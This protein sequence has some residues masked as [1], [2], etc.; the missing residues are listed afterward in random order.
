MA[1]LAAAYRLQQA[2]F[3]VQVL[4]AEDH[5]GGRA[6]AHRRD[7]GFTLNT[8]ATVLSSSYENMIGLAT[9][10][11]LEDRFVKV[12]PTVGI[13]A[14]GKVHWLRGAGPGA[15]IDFIRTPLLSAKSKLLL[16]KA[17]KDAFAARKK[18]GYG[19]AELRA[20]LDTE[21]VEEYC[22]R[23]LNR[24]I[25]DRL[26]SPLMGSL[27]V[28]DGDKVSVAELHF[29]LVKFLG[30]GMLG[31]R[32][33]IDFL[34]QALAE[35]VPVELEAKVSL[36]EDLGDGARVVWSQNGTEH[37][38]KV[39]GA[40]STLTASQVPALI[41]GLEPDLQA[42]L[43]EGIKAANFIG[44]RFMLSR[45]P[46]TDGLIVAVP[47]DEFGGLGTV[48]FEH[49]ANPD[50]APPGKGVIAILTYHEWGTPRLDRSDEEL[51][52]EVLGDLDRMFPGTAEIVEDCE[53]TRW[54]PG[55]LRSEPGMHKLIAEVDR[56]IDDDRRVQLAGDYL[57]VAS[58]NGSI[59]TGE[60]AAKRLA[61][62]IGNGAAPR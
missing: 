48:V 28:V 15:A 13:A 50:A 41:P 59:L 16:M 40:I 5:V 44:F 6:Y 32:E 26:L 11:G 3:E 31:Y 14:D 49:N 17:A 52:E 4:E 36:L 62:A 55:S 12:K 53:V 20:E 51:I 23:R 22:D 37:D 56:R 21:S 7:D 24:E 9:E 8:G 47:K 38:E 27:F 10:L 34:A 61:S 39:A 35:R 19:N 18:A 60:I 54:V 58:V 1:G 43:N 33:G 46:D 29:S 42:I 30:G 2:G 57:T 25:L 45:K